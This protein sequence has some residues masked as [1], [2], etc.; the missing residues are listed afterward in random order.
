MVE[1]HMIDRSTPLPKYMGSLGKGVPYDTVVDG[2]PGGL[3]R[4]MRAPDLADYVARCV[5]KE[6]VNLWCN[7]AGAVMPFLDAVLACVL[8]R[9]TRGRDPADRVAVVVHSPYDPTRMLRERASLEDVERRAADMLSQCRAYVA[10]G[11][12]SRGGDCGRWGTRLTPEG[13][14]HV[15]NR[16]VGPGWRACAIPNNAYR[17][18]MVASPKRGEAWFFR[19]N[20]GASVQDHPL[21]VRG[22][23][24]AEPDSVFECTYNCLM[25]SVTIYDCATA[26][27]ANVRAR[28]LTERI[29]LAGRIA[30]G[31]TLGDCGKA[32]RIAAYDGTGADVAT[33][34]IVL[35]VRDAAALGVYAGGDAYVWKEPALADGQCVMLYRF[36]ECM[37]AESA[38]HCMLAKV[39][40][41]H[42]DG[43]PAPPPPFPM[44]AGVFE[45]LPRTDMWRFVR[46]ARRSERLFSF[47][48][49]TC[50]AREPSLTPRSDMAK[51]LLRIGG[52]PPPPQSRPGPPAPS[53]HPD[54]KTSKKISVA[55]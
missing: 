13:F 31:W 34:K 36:G 8:M 44:S 6:S 28:P 24:P 55:P 27:G 32:P 23:D 41:V 33:A 10:I 26:A 16:V 19:V 14:P 22:C 37:A 1:V 50:S 17:C 45:R 39:G 11:L 3:V 18:M 20:G 43:I 51:L 48:E 49:C 40:D 21:A 12:P 4:E 52:G 9:R 47:A 15:L 35:F 25:E 29:A 54:P 7:Y 38:A 42:L 30:R 53:A 5:A 2:T 46:P